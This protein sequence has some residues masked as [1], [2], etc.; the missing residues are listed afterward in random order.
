VNPS[1]TEIERPKRAAWF[2]LLFVLAACFAVVLKV[3]AP[4]F[5]V[6]LLAVVAAGLLNPVYRRL[7]SAFKG[8]R[9]SAAILI[10]LLLLV[11]LLVPVFF[12]TQEV[13]EE[14][15]DIYEMSTTQLT[16][17]RLL[18]VLAERQT[19]IDRVNLL[20]EPF[21]FSLTVDDVSDL[22]GTL[23]VRIG[24]F[25]Y[26]QGVSLA[27]HLVRF[28]FS[29]V[30]WVLVL[31][32]LL[33]DG[34]VFRN[35]V[36]ETVPLPANE[37]EMVAHRFMDMASSLVIGNG[38][39][40][41]IQ[42]TVGGGLFASLGIQGAVLWGVVMAILAFIPVV[43]VSLIY[44]PFTIIL[45]V[46]GQTT[47]ALVLFVI[48]LIVST[49]VEYWLKPILVGRRAQMHTLLVFLSLIGGVVAFGAV[50]L[51]LG[52]LMMT[53]F[54]TLAGIY[55]EHYRPFIGE[56]CVEGPPETEAKSP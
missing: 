23:G 27:K 40:A 34:P 25:F 13:S 20:L 16:Q 15:L 24:G 41:F 21:G 5:S 49:V 18:E 19:Q 30:F 3:L 28:V 22:I 46:A 53:A 51:L 11:V 38:A 54:L 55:R 47:R 52:P 12:I 2:G 8:H 31:Y 14:A 45:L 9:R 43:G 7:V 33:V 1:P 56:P 6:I 4:F 37:Q 36:E 10:C 32:Y 44:I 26:K 39:A 50:G 42:G 29:F 48:L 35:W 17:S